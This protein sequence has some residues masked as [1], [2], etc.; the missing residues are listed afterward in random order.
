MITKAQK[1][2]IFEAW[3]YC[4]EEDKSTEFMFQYMSDVSK[5]DYDDI[6]DYICTDESTEER[7]AY[8]KKTY[9]NG[10]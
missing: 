4:D 6:V 9:G 3:N 7:S 1:V 8:N 10:E 2:A 5:V